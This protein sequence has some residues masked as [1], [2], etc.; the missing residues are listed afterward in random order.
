MSGMGWIRDLPDPRDHKLM[1]AA[2]EPLL[3]ADDLDLEPIPVVP[4]LDQGNLG[5]CTA[6]TAAYGYGHLKGSAIVLSRLFQYYN[7]RIL[8]GTIASDSGASIRNTIKALVDYGACAETFWEYDIVRY[9]ET[10]PQAAYD[11]ASLGQVIEYLSVDQTEQSIFGALLGGYPI[12]FG[13]LIYRQFELVGPT[14]IVQMPNK[15]DPPLGGHSQW[16]FGWRTIAGKKYIRSRNSWGVDH[17]DHGYVYIPIE[18]LLDRDLAADFWVIKAIEPEPEP[19]PPTPPIPPTPPHVGPGVKKL[20]D[21]LGDVPSAIEWY[22]KDEYGNAIG[23]SLA[24][25]QTRLYVYIASIDSVFAINADHIL[26]G[27]K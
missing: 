7:A 9:R 6:H 4:T 20:M 15:N 5:S 21:Q 26:K 23:W 8:E 17:G 16:A 14:G 2:P 22:P 25:G 1:V 13:M 10:P 24:T 11:R 19:S 12:M 3:L 27:T 18:Y